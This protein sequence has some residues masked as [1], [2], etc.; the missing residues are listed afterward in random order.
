MGPIIAGVIRRQHRQKRKQRKQNTKF[1][2]LLENRKEH[3]HDKGLL[4]AK[5]SQ[6][7]RTLI[8]FH[9]HRSPKAKETQGQV[10]DPQISFRDEA[11]KRASTSQLRSDLHDHHEHY[12]YSPLDPG[13]PSSRFN[14]APRSITTDTPDK[15]AQSARKDWKRHGSGLTQVLEEKRRSVSERPGTFGV[16]ILSAESRLDVSGAKYT[17]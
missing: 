4:Q 3:L 7:R 11:S 14:A 6:P 17:A 8:M 12:A 13:T 15:I 2:A 5:T 10:R 16:R 1:C 9:E